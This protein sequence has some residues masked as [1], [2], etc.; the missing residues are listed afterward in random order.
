MALLLEQPKGTG[1]EHGAVT[2]ALRWF[3]TNGKANG[4]KR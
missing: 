1:Q 4:A 2:L 3:R